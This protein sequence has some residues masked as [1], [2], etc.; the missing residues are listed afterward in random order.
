MKSI[1]E[2]L[3]RINGFSIPLGGISWN[4]KIDEKKEVYS[5]LQKL[6]NKRILDYNHGIIDKEASISS[7][8]DMR[9]Y[10]TDTLSRI[11][12]DSRIRTNLENVRSILMAFQT[13][14]EHQTVIDDKGNIRMDK[15]FIEALQN[16]RI[17]INGNASN[18]IENAEEL[19]KLPIDS[20][21]S[22]DIIKT[23]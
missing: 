16:V 10:I 4:P 22:L 17:L 7:I 18:F 13:Y 8:S 19:S 23:E 3:N 20:N 2:F 6:S 15:D 5:L 9:E 1:K 12:Q 11:P 14:V 21:G